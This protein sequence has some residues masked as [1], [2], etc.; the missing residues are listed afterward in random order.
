MLLLTE[1]D[2]F[3]TGREDLSFP[4]GGTALG[5]VLVGWTGG[6]E[7]VPTGCWGAIMVVVVEL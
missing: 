3:S 2:W 6:C 5:S 4:R 1:T 7:I